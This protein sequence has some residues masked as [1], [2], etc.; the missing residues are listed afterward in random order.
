LD[1]KEN[2]IELVK[3]LEMV[4]RFE[5]LNKDEAEVLMRIA[6]KMISM[7]KQFDFESEMG[8][9]IPKKTEGKTTI[10]DKIITALENNPDGLKLK[11]LKKATGVENSSISALLSKV[12][13]GKMKVNRMIE[14]F[15]G[16]WRLVKNDQKGKVE[17]KN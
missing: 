10:Y 8:T 14:R 9:H 5:Y 12:T 11:E 13:H 1:S 6:G 16:K 2:R 4:I 3:G 17:R 15:G 7:S